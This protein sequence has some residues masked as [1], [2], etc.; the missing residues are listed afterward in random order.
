MEIT[1]EDIGMRVYSPINGWGTIE[2]VDITPIARE[3]AA[4]IIFDKAQ[5]WYRLNGK[6]VDDC[7]F[8]DV[9]SEPTKPKRKVKREG[10]MNI[11]PGP[12]TRSIYPTKEEAE[13]NKGNGVIDCVKIEWEE[14]D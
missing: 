10:W 8:W 9:P 1:K 6:R 13:G 2:K 12:M 14:D 7:V 11:Y 5:N 4:Y 3:L